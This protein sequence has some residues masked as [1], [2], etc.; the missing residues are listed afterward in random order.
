LKE[1]HTTDG[2]TVS[3]KIEIWL[4]GGLVS[5]TII[6]DIEFNPELPDSL[7]AYPNDK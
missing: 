3:H 1:Y 2:Y 5:E 6:Q 4:G 7:F